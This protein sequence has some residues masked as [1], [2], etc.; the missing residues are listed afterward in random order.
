MI[1]WTQYSRKLCDRLDRP[2]FKGYFSA[3]EA[4]EK[5]MRRVLGRA[6]DSPMERICLYWL[7]DETDG[8]IA[9][10]K[11]QAIGPTGLIGSAEA[12]SEAVLRKNY[13]QASRLTADLLDRVM[14]GEPNRNAFPNACALAIEA[15]AQ[16]VRGCQGIPFREMTPIGEGLVEISGGVANWNEMSDAMRRK[17]IEEVIEKIKLF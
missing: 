5:G 14:Q 17:I 11:Y 15:I 2:R 16:A 8:I 10:A 4:Q 7:V 9:D 6:G 13:D 12:A 1:L 3:M